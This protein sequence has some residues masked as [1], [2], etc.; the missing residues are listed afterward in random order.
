M[1]ELLSLTAFFGTLVLI[2][3]AGGFFSK[4]IALWHSFVVGGIIGCSLFGAVLILPPQEFGVSAAARIA[5]VQGLAMTAATFTGI[6]LGR[7]ARR[8]WNNARDHRAMQP[9]D[10]QDTRYEKTL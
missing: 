8:Y 5:A 6:W 7:Q 3:A 4:Q 10:A 2:A 9:E 1:S